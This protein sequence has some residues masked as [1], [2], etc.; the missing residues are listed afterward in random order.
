[1]SAAR[2]GSRS[3]LY[4]DLASP[5]AYLA[6]ERAA[7]VLPEAPELEPVLVGA[8]FK[9]RGSGS[10]AHTPARDM[11]AAEVEARAAR[12]GLA[13]VAWPVTWP[14]NALPAMRAATWAKER[15]RLEFFARA[16][17]RAEFV[18]GQD[19]A[20]LAVLAAAA[21]EAGLDGDE[22]VE[23]IQRP[24]VKERLRQATAAAWEAG[25][26]GVPTLIAGGVVYYGDDQLELAAQAGEARR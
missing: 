4:F 7:R 16:V 21:T 2:L 5:Y 17:Y 26:R 12:Y 3:V 23:A 24:E 6:V 20:D 25:V 22:L 10:W 13:P 18:R 19:I 11:R 9:L 15:G 8:I 14:A 1:V